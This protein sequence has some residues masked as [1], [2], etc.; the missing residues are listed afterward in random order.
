M[1]L[2]SPHC[3]SPR[4]APTCVVST[5]GERRGSRL[6]HNSSSTNNLEAVSYSPHALHGSPSQPTDVQ[7]FMFILQKVAWVSTNTAKLCCRRVNRSRHK[8]YKDVDQLP[9]TLTPML[10]RHKHSSKDAS[11]TQLTGYH[12][13]FISAHP[14]LLYDIA[15]S[16]RH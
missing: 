9:H 6:V 11:R 16:C 7:L 2:P 14:N 10:G 5:T 15:Y 8:T 13:V 1:W 12:V 3:G 4:H